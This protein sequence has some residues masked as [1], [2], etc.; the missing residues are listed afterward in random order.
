MCNGSVCDV[1]LKVLRVLME[2]KTKSKAY[3]SSFNQDNL[4]KIFKKQKGQVD[5][6]IQEPLCFKSWVLK[7][8]FFM[9]YYL[10]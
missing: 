5:K 4:K 9:F 10:F 3:D 6:L 1:C 8:F 7:H 2:D